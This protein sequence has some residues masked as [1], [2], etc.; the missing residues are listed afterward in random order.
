MYKCDLCDK[1]FKLKKYLDQH[2]NKKNNCNIITDYKC[3]SCNRYFKHKK[4]LTLHQNNNTCGKI[5]DNNLKQNN[6]SSKDDPI[7][8]IIKSTI[9]SDDDFNTKLFFI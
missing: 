8:E 7:Y 5:N 9:N 1:E 6:E 2:L 3:E 4:N